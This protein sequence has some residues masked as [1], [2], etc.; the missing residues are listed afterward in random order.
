MPLSST[1]ARKHIPV[2]IG[3]LTGLKNRSIPIEQI[4]NQVAI[5]RN[6]GFSGVSFFFY[7]SLWS[8]AI[9]T[10]AQ[11]EEA[12]RKLFTLGVEAPDVL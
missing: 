7:E 8:W 4:Q 6:L 10:P 3:I 5:V 2:G 11:R 9:E 12:F 1:A